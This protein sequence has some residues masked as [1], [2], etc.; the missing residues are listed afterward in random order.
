[1]NQ[2]FSL[3]EAAYRYDR[4]RP[5]VHNIVVDWLAKCFGTK[6]WRHGID[7]ACGTGDSTVPLLQICWYVEILGT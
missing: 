3:K 4:F 1:M 7:I 6:R 5:Q 2:F